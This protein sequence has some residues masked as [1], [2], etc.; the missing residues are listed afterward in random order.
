MYDVQAAKKDVKRMSSLTDKKKFLSL[1]REVLYQDFVLIILFVIYIGIG[2][3]FLWSKDLFQY[4][5]FTLYKTIA[6]LIFCILLFGKLLTYLVKNFVREGFRFLKTDR[7][8][9]DL[10]TNWLNA[11][12][13]ITVVVPLLLFPVLLSFSSSIKSLIQIINPYYLDLPLFSLD[14]FIHFGFNPWEITHALIGSVAVTMA[15]DFIY[16]IWFLVLMFYPFWMILNYKI[17]VTRSK[18]LVC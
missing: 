8:F 4:A 14:R 18:F 2:S 12:V 11:N 5:H 16:Q 10:K 9:N 6:S 1:D 7:L 17:G 13:I 3:V 15:I